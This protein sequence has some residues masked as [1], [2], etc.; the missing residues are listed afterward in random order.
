[1]TEI[2]L[3]RLNIRV[4]IRRYEAILIGSVMLLSGAV[5]PSSWEP[6][7]RYLPAPKVDAPPQ[8]PW[9]ALTF[10]DGPHPARTEE[11]LAVLRQEH[12]PGTFFVVGKMA[13]RYPQLVR[14]IARD[15]HQLANHTYNHY[16]MSRLSE[17]EVLHELA[18]TR[19]VVQRLT[20]QD[21]YLFRPPGGDYTRHVVRLTARAGYRMVL[22][23]VLTDDVEGATP[24]AMRRRILQGAEDGAV[25]LMHSGVKSTVQVLPEVIAKLR[26]RGF[27]FVTV[28]TLMGLPPAMQAPLH[29]LPAVQTASY[30][31]Y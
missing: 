24:R 22:W 18:Q 20:G 11:L 2:I 26:E 1:M 28:S 29:D 6:P 15:G 19:D 17:D 16:D 23:S 31:K 9:I 12:V 5:M 30:K 3:R 13:D 27:N 14:A 8:H 4:I 10:D 25:I 7:L 21:A